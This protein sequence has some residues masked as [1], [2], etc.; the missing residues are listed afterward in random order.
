MKA[1]AVC[2][3]LLLILPGLAAS[4]E[5]VVNGGFETGDFTGWT[6]SGNADAFFDIT[7]TTV[8]SGNYAGV[9]GPVD[10]LGFLS[11]T[12][13]TM[14]GLTYDI[15][16]WLLNADGTHGANV[17]R[18]IWD[19][20]TIVNS[21]NMAAFDYT[22]YSYSLQATSFSTV[23]TFG[24]RHDPSHFALDDVSV[25]APTPEP[26]TFGLIGLGLMGLA[27]LQRKLA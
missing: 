9:F 8:H 13:S 2:A 24:F 16:F 27:L 12:L 20:N 1:C 19:G 6:Q 23:L 26:V 7:L 17:F 5:L 15:N 4:A 21:N 3:A 18:F 14:P 22:L 11:Q 25:D 10:S